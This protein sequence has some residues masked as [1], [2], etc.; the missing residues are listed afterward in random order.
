MGS[1]IGYLTR[2]LGEDTVAPAA[3]LANFSLMDWVAII[4]TVGFFA[5]FIEGEDKKVSN[6]EIFELDRSWDVVATFSNLFR[7]VTKM[8]FAEDNAIADLAN[9]WAIATT[10]LALALGPA[11][12]LLESGAD[13]EDFIDLGNGATYLLAEYT[14]VLDQPF[15]DLLMSAWYGYSEGYGS[16]WAWVY[17]WQALLGGGYLGSMFDFPHIF[18]SAGTMAALYMVIE[19]GQ[20]TTI[21]RVVSNV[22]FLY[23]A[24]SMLVQAQEG[25]AWYDMID[26]LPSLFGWFVFP[27]MIA[28]AFVHLWNY[29]GFGHPTLDNEWQVDGYHFGINSASDNRSFALCLRNYSFLMLAYFSG[30]FDFV[31]TNWIAAI[32]GAAY[33]LVYT[34]VNEEDT[35]DPF[36]FLEE[37]LDFWLLIL[38]AIVG[39]TAQQV[40]LFMQ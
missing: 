1:F 14:D 37:T 16:S 24:S 39:G 20:D 40:S 33:V 26:G 2:F 32:L 36:E 6:N 11:A 12:N 3:F 31:N 13:E 30:Y 4:K 35:E 9:K 28:W 18:L 34:M 23:F 17:F 27:E 8:L 22:T 5:F 21:Q 15:M 38:Y 7:F 10:G 29:M 25:S 19:E